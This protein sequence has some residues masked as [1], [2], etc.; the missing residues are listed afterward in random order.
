MNDEPELFDDTFM[1]YARR[2]L[3]MAGIETDPNLKDLRPIRHSIL[4]AISEQGSHYVQAR[5]MVPQ[6]HAHWEQAEFMGVALRAAIWDLGWGAI[7]SYKQFRFLYSRLMSD[8]ALPYLPSVFAAAALS[9][10]VGG[11][12]GRQLLD[13]LMDDID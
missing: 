3:E 1:E 6:S 10:S 7:T 12:F 9:P 4:H 5:K 2:A 13:T 8:A 11:E